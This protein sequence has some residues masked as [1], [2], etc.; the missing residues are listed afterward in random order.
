MNEE[1]EQP[2]IIR[3]EETTSTNNYLR[4]LVGKEPLSLLQNIRRPDG[5]RSVTLG[6]RNRERI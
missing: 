5:A 4:G 2:R 3:L 1:N 6:S